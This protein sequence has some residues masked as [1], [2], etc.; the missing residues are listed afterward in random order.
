MIEFQ[1]VSKVFTSKAKEVT[2]LKDVDLTVN[3]GDIFGVIGFS[4]AGKST[5]VRTVNLLETPTSGKVL[6]N[7]ENLAALPKKQLRQAQKGIGM[8]FQ[9]FHLLNS[10]TVYDNVAMPLLL[11]KVKKSEIEKRVKETLDLDRKSTRLN[12]SHVAISYAVFC[13]K[14]KNRHQDSMLH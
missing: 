5:L 14:K 8:I 9:H 3:K 11:S 13:L 12:S 10:K 1:N 4:G 7:G 2:A 6:V